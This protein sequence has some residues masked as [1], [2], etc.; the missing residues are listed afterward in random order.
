M[1]EWLIMKWDNDIDIRGCIQNEIYEAKDLSSF[2][3]YLAREHSRA[4]TV[5]TIS[6]WDIEEESSDIEAF[7]SLWN[8]NSEGEL[9][10]DFHALFRSSASVE[11]ADLD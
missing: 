7:E 8:N 9:L 10:T 4:M 5:R 6:Y 3:N 11:G 1:E 2:I